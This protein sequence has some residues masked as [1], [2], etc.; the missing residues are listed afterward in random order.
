MEMNSNG[1]GGNDGDNDN[2]RRGAPA[3][4]T[5]A[6]TTLEKNKYAEHKYT[7]ID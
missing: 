7:Q 3:T 2:G 4:A 5:T 6:Q 1:M